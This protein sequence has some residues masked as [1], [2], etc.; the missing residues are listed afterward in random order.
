MPV[1]VVVVPATP[2][3]VPGAAGGA[4]VLG[5][6]RDLVAAALDEL[7]AGALPD[8]VCH[9]AS[10]L[11]G[12]TGGPRLLVLAPAG[13]DGARGPGTTSSGRVRSGRLRPSLAGAG[14]DDRWLT[15]ATPLAWGPGPRAQVPASVALLCLGAALDARG[16]G[17]L[18]SEVEVVEV[19]AE[20][21]AT[22]QG[23]VRE[24]LR[25]ADAVVAAGGDEPA[26][27]AALEDVALQAGWAR[28]VRSAAEMHEHLAGRYD[29][30]LLRGGDRA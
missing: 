27:G 18:L 3:L 2:L 19:P 13:R 29:V 7:L 6:T 12:S 8:A 28:E 24:R 10:H 11:A 25:R 15:R 23:L 22:D 21:S 16:R 30:T 9:P 17:R 20:P 1:R 4:R 14:V 26:V 5:A